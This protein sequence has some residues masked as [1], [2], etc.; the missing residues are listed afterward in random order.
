MAGAWITSDLQGMLSEAEFAVPATWSPVGDSVTYRSTVILSEPDAMVL[1]RGGALPDVSITLTQNDFPGISQ[2]DIVIV[3]VGVGESRRFRVTGPV[4]R[5]G[6]GALKVLECAELS[7]YE[8][9]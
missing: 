2:N 6:D 3:E 9:I 8:V 7:E 4:L 1:D 5:S